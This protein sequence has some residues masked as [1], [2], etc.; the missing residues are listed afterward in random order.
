MRD[1]DRQMQAEATSHRA[2]DD[3]RAKHTFRIIVNADPK[4]VDKKV[5]TFT[6]VV[7]LAFPNPSTD[8]NVIY[9]VVYKKAA[10]P[11]HE[12]SM[13]MGD[14]VEVKNGTIFSVTPTNKS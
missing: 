11:T 8:P 7:T 3:E 9:T 14:K 1:E 5:L 10:G 12:G 13:E 4:E 2:H 6:E